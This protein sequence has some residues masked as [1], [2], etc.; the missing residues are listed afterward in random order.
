MSFAS[1]IQTLDRWIKYFAGNDAARKHA[2][3]Q[4]DCA[5]KGAWKRGNP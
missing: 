1:S 5:V 2:E 4:V 3:Y